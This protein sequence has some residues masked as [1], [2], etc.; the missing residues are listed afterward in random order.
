MISDHFAKHTL[1]SSLLPV[2]LVHSTKSPQASVYR[3][4]T[5]ANY[6]Y[7]AASDCP[8]VCG[9]PLV[10]SRHQV[11]RYI[12]VWHSPA[13]C[14]ISCRVFK[15]TCTCCP[16]LLYLSDDWQPILP[17]CR[18]GKAHMQRDTCSMFVQWCQ[19]LLPVYSSLK[20]PLD[21]LLSCWG[22]KLG[23]YLE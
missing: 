19:V 10:L 2:C 6:S 11:M 16:D 21:I 18:W 8:S 13:W 9:S 1:E 20:S 15:L 22:N 7:R 23:C 14:M 17:N 4:K 3:Q 5:L 12:S